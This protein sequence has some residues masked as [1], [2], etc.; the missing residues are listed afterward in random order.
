MCLQVSQSAHI[1]TV[2]GNGRE[3]ETVCMVQSVLF[4]NAIVAAKTHLTETFAGPLCD[5]WCLF[6]S[7]YASNPLSRLDENI[8]VENRVH[9]L[10]RPSQNIERKLF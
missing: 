1:V 4:K 3:S 7:C 9:K 10:N 6:A 5:L 8:S 2:S